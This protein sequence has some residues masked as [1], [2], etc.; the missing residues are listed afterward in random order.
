ML[1]RTLL[2]SC[3]PL[4]DEKTKEKCGR[5]FEKAKQGMFQRERLRKLKEREC[6]SQGREFQRQEEEFH[7][8]SL[9]AQRGMWHL[10]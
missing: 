7:D 3:Q 5:A 10:M 8:S 9:M 6:A 4:A 2:N 1:G